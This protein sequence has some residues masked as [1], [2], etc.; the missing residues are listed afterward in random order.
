MLIAQDPHHQL[1]NASQAGRQI[2]YIC[3]GC[4]GPVRL[5]R[6]SVM[7]AH[8]AHFQGSDCQVFS[9]GETHEHVTGKQQL[10]AWFAASGYSV[11]L[12]AG[13]TA[14]HQRPDLLV[15]TDVTPPLAI[16][17][18]CSPLSVTRLA[19]RTHG[20]WQHGYQVL[21]ILGQPYQRK[22]RSTSKA[23]KFLQYHP[24]WGVHL[25]FWQVETASLQ[26]IHHILTLDAEPLT[27]QRWSLKSARQPV[28][29]FQQFQPIVSNPTPP[30]EHL[31]HYHRQ[32][33]LARLRHQHA[34][35]DLQ[36][37]CYQR[38]G[39][40][41]QLPDWTIPRVP[42]LPLLT[43]PYLVW[44]GHVF[45]QLRQEP[46]VI[47]HERLQALLWAELQ[48]LLARQACLRDQGTLH[49]QLL[50]AITARLDQQHVIQRRGRDWTLNQAALKWERPKF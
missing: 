50:L 40:I 42:E 9:E 41:A 34:F 28:A 39:T 13:L 4:Q 12:E 22:L 19:A 10:A 31:E 30:E 23:L 35:D 46:T 1:V 18:Q 7:T 45:G 16:E 29:A 26:L 20:Y 43:V 25:L 44:Y 38:G 6:G 2:P 11:Q 32:L 37:Y 3:P 17:F 15:Q 36:R 49:R 33:L 47:T 8:F 24:H 27:Y 48:P 14:L 5:K 21:W